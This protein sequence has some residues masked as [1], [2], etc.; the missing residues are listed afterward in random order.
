MVEERAAV[1]AVVVVWG[2]GADK[3]PLAAA[4][5][6]TEAEVLAPAVSVSVPDAARRYRTREAKN[7]RT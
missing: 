5:V 4:V 3:D 1:V 7:V 6:A 2:K